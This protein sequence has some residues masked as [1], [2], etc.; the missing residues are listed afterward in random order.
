LLHAFKVV[1]ENV[2]LCLETFCIFFFIEFTVLEVI[3]VLCHNEIVIVERPIIR[4]NVDF[5]FIVLVHLRRVMSRNYGCH[6]VLW[7]TL[8]LQLMSLGHLLEQRL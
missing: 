1:V 7:I 3:Q 4:V 5:V 6:K 2:F 8:L